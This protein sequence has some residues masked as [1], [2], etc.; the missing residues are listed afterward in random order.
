MAAPKSTRLSDRERGAERL[1][2]S[3][4]ACRPFVI[5]AVQAMQFCRSSTRMRSWER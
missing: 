2:D 4:C 1:W 5:G 3:T